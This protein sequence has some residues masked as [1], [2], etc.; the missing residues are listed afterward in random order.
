M[1]RHIV[2]WTF[3][4]EAEGHTGV[5]NALMMKEG[6]EALMGRIP[7]LKSIELSVDFE[8]TS[9]LPVSLILNSTHDDMDGLKAYA[10]HPEHQL[11][12]EF[13]KATTATRQAI[14]YHF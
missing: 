9:T 1:I 8:S 5:A 11:L 13:A 10:N 14:D 3:K 12:I 6:C 7:S 4:P 2:W